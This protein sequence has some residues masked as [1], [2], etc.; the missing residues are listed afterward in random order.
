MSLRDNILAAMQDA[1]ELG[2]PNTDE[3]Y[4][5]LMEEV[6]VVA[7]VRA[8]EVRLRRSLAGTQTTSSVRAAVFVNGVVSAIAHADIEP[9]KVQSVI[10]AV[11]NSVQGP[12]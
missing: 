1:D 7:T 12:P 3:E 6:S 9:S 2:G 10:E 8:N 5:A 4:I 11:V